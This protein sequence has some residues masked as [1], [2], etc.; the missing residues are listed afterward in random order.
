MLM[1]REGGSCLVFKKRS[2]S[3]KVPGVA[4]EKRETIGYGYREDA[5]IRSA[6][7]K[8]APERPEL[9]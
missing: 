2:S 3:R 4:G 5:E 1:V 7:V 8:A 9:L 6:A